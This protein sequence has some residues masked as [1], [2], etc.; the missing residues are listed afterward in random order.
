MEIESLVRALSYQSLLAL[1]SS[2]QLVDDVLRYAETHAKTRE[3]YWHHKR[4]TPV[5]VGKGGM[6]TTP[7]QVLHELGVAT[8]LLTAS[9]LSQVARHWAA[10]RYC[11]TIT[12]NGG[13]LALTPDANEVVYH[14]KVTQSEQ[15]GVGLALVVAKNLL[16]RQYRGWT[17]HA[18][19]AEVALKAGFVDGGGAVES[20]SRTKKRPDYILLGHHAT[21][22]RRR[23]KIVILECKGTHGPPNFIHGQLARAAVQVEAL[24]VGGSHPPSLMVASHLTQSGITAY[25]LDPPGDDELWSGDDDELDGLL[26]TTPEDQFWHPRTAIPQEPEARQT[27]TGAL[28]PADEAVAEPDL[29]DELPPGAP[30]VFDIPEQQRGWFTQILT[31]AVAATALLFAGN[32]TAASGYATPRQRGM[33]DPALQPALFNLDP[34]WATSSAATFSLPNGLSAEGTRHRA[35]LGQGRT[36]EVFRGVESR[37]YRELAEGQVGAYL[38]DA[39]S[40]FRQRAEPPNDGGVYSFGRDGTVLVVRVVEGRD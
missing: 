24:S 37:L 18:V 16:R 5:D 30:Q 29:P 23:M 6:R 11:A 17:F 19:D 13:R 40:F 15:L 10:V 21:K 22:T 32:N 7:A 2:D 31:R 27:P 38:R 9:P 36:L 35:P 3:A 1:N 8:T 12:R 33:E 26:S 20:V 14:H 34:A 25:V 28:S 4:L 39:P